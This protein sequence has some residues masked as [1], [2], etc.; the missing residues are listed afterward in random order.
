MLFATLATANRASES[1]LDLLRTSDYSN[2]F[3]CTQIPGRS[4]LSKCCTSPTDKTIRCLPTFIIAGVQKGGTTALSA[5]LSNH[6]QVSFAA[7][8]E[9]H[10]F[11]RKSNA[12]KKIESYLNSFQTWNYTQSIFPPVVGESTPFYI[13]SRFACKRI[14]QE[15]PNV[16]IIILLR[17]PVARAYS[18]Y[19]MKKR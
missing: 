15:I 19:L 14:A 1:V 5:F 4:H 16:K 2:E 17:N 7:K 18:E 8:K 13:A 9:V 10:F 3:S 11:D 6:S 12:N